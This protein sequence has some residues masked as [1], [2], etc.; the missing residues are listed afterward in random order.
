MTKRV[1]CACGCVRGLEFRGECGVWVRARVKAIRVCRCCSALAAVLLVLLVGAAGCDKPADI[2]PPELLGP[3]TFDLGG[4]EKLEMVW[5]PAGSFTMG[6]PPSEADRDSDEAQHRVTLTRGFWLGKY[7]V[8]Q[9]QWEAVMGSNPSHFKGS[10]LPVEQVSWDDCQEFIRKLNAR[11]ASEGGGY[12]LPTESEWEYA[13]RAGTT[14]PYAGR[15]DDM[16][17]YSGN[18]GG[19]THPVGQK[20][21]NGWGLY[22]MHGNVW[23]WCEDWYGSYPSGNVEDPRGAAGGACRVFRGGSWIINPWPCRS[24][25]RYWHEP[26]LRYFHLGFRLARTQL[27][28]R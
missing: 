4:G 9:G 19:R 23:E 16:G 13:C 11:F 14:G 2:T 26:G 8:T 22:D 6:S 5:V 20:A 21:P 28:S 7:E 17:W 24:A 18:A 27:P 12:R 15:L 1:G 10:N 25:I 3:R